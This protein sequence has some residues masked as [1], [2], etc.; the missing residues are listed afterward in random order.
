VSRF[1]LD[2]SIVSAPMQKTPNLRVLAQ[3]EAHGASSA[4]ASPVWHE[5]LFGCRRLP[6]GRRRTELEAYLDEVVSTTLPVLP[7]D[8]LAAAWHAAERARLETAGKAAPFVDGQI[9]A[10]AATRELT[11]VTTN[12]ADFRYFRGLRIVDWSRP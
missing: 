8:E 3:L 1:L 10:V 11:L 9:A 7:Y 4:I 2:T 12:V 5:L 6:R